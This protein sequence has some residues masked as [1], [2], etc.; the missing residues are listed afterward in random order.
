MKKM[1]LFVPGCIFILLKARH[2]ILTYH[3]HHHL[4]CCHL[5]VVR[6]HDEPEPVARDGPDAKG[7]HEDGKV[8]SRL[9]ELAQKLCKNGIQNLIFL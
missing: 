8:L 1:F 7:R 4:F 2:A 5:P 6:L 3:P 9:H